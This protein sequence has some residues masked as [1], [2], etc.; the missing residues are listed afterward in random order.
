MPQQGVDHIIA[1]ADGSYIRIVQPGK[2]KQ[3]RQWDWK[4]IRLV[5][6]Q[7]KDQVQARYAVTFQTVEEA[8]HRLGH[9]AKAV[10]RGLNTRIHALGDGAKWIELR[11]EEVFGTMMSFLCDF[12]HVSEYL[13]A[14]GKSLRARAPKSWMKTQQRRLRRNDVGQVLRELSP[15]LEPEHLPDERAP[16]R[17][18]H[19]YLSNRLDQ[20]DYAGALANDLPIGSGLVESGHRHILQ[21][22]MKCSGF[23][24]LAPNAERMAQLRVFRANDQWK[25]L[26]N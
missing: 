18:A 7:A 10:G 11:V 14:A 2:R 3:K 22:R 23:G 16:V 12:F 13:Y 21:A 24:W 26:W 1:E 20:L 25:T 5:A 15:G 4:E 19:R 9:C 6:A 8:A 17:Q